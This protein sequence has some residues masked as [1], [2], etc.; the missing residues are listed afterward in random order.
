VPRLWQANDLEPVPDGGGHL[1]LKRR[2]EIEAAFTLCFPQYDEL[3]LE[4]IND[5]VEVTGVIV[6]PIT[7]ELEAHQLLGVMKI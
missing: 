1:P 5:T 6:N 4:V 7:E 3:L 2:R